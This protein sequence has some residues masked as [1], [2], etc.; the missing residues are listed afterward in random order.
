MQEKSIKTANLCQVNSP[1]KS[2]QTTEN[3]EL[4]IF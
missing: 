1:E 2:F 3:K 4:A